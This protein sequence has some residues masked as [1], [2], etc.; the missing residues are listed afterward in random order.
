MKA[1]AQDPLFIPLPTPTEMARWDELTEAEYGLPRLVLMESAAREAFH[2]L[3]EQHGIWP[4]LRV[5][6]LAGG[7]NNGGDGIALARILHNAGCAVRL[8]TMWAGEEYSGIA[9][10]HYQAALKGGVH[11]MC[12]AEKDALPGKGGPENSPETSPDYPEVIVD[13]VLGA[14]FKGPL[15]PP[16][17]TL[18][19]YMNRM[20]ESYIFSLD[21]P[22][23]LNAVT[24]RP[25]P[26]AVRAKLTAAFG[27]AKSGL[28]LPW[29]RPYTGILQICDIGIPQTLMTAR[30]P[31]RR[32]VRPRPG[33]LPKSSP[34][35]HKGQKGRVLV[36]GGSQGF[37]GA[38]FLSAL[39]AAR[40]GVGLITV[41]AP[42]PVCAE[43]SH[44]SPEIMT[45]PL[46][47]KDWAEIVNGPG[48]EELKSFISEMA[49]N[50]A[51][52]L[53][54][55]LGRDAG[56]A[57]LAKAVVTMPG[58]PPLVLDADGLFPFRA[59]PPE[60]LEGTEYLSLALLRE[61]DVA[62]PHPGEMYRLLSGSRIEN[63]AVYPA[64]KRP[65]GSSDLVVQEGREAGLKAA[66]GQ[67]YAAVLLKG[68]GSIAG[69]AGEP[70]SI[71]SFATEAL[72]V[73]GS[74][75]VLSGLIAALLARSPITGFT[76][77]KAAA[78]GAWLHGRAGELCARQ[79]PAGGNLASDIAEAIPKALAELF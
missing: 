26:V 14:G 77:D 53:G 79:F 5:L 17:L 2:A 11:I 37:V 34:Y 63:A 33:I 32:L 38:P 68:P 31:A 30:T 6:V 21:I 71:A 62:T 3:K 58:R 48:L 76:S 70:M 65:F 22:S 15:R 54:P 10:T 40:S 51:L 16:A 20:S 35:A 64:V 44:R 29:A 28:A 27:A 12:M 1:I 46:P 7:G 23:G 43:A 42:A 4:G 36:I 41:A 55:G 72:G 18:V 50:S 69:K 25:E 52:V 24:G 74:G 19:S 61:Y 8:V 78:L 66:V 56:A 75:D 47:G 39:G 67:T 45:L 49:E 13:A 59:L 57:A 60:E 9:Q 73:G